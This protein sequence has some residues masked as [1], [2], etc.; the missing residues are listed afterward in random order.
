MLRPPNSEDSA[1]NNNNNSDNTTTTG[2]NT[3]LPLTTVEELL[4]KDF[5]ER[6]PNGSL[7]IGQQDSPLKVGKSLKKGWTVKR[8]LQPK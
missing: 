2:Q 5:V 8:L 7:R 1:D 6:G 4:K 3:P